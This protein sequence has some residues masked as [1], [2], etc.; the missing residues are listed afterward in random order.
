MHSENEGTY[1][2]FTSHRARDNALKRLA[3]KPQ[4][5][6]SWHRDTGQGVYLLTQDQLAAIQG[7]KGWR[8]LRGPYDD[9]MKCI[10]W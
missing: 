9:L 2:I 3:E 6:Y 8:R 4:G 7:C 10:D 5:Y 1:V